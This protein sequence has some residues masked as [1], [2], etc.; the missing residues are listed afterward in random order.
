MMDDKT[1]EN[2]VERMAVKLVC[3]WDFERVWR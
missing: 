3:G 2:L 1:V